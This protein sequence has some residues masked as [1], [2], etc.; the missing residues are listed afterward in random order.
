MS[1]FKESI[2]RYVDELDAAVKGFAVGRRYKCCCSHYYLGLVS[3]N[4][5]DG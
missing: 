3:I 4:I 2:V 1:R 5:I